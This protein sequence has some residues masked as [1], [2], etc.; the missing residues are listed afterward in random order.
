MSTPVHSHGPSPGASTSVTRAPHP[1][2]RESRRQS[3]NPVSLFAM[4][5]GVLF[6]FG[7]YFG[8]HTFAMLTGVLFHFV[9][10]MLSAVDCVCYDD[11]YG[12]FV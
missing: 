4:L 6:R 9:V 10:I 1:E 2:S 7:N 11:M 5:T 8:L 12:V 3:P